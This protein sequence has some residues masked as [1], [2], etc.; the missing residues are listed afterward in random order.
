MV[1]GI[2]NNDFS[3]VFSKLLGKT[4]ISC[5]QIHNFTHIDQAYLSRLRSGEKDNPSP[6]IIVKICLAFV[7]LSK[8]VTLYDIEQLLNSVG[9]SINL[10]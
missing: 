7:R 10:R 9:R 1:T 8:N 2:Y 4:G 5:Y 3:L 6:E